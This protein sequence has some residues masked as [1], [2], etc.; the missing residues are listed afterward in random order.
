MYFTERIFITAFYGYFGK[1]VP[2]FQKMRRSPLSWFGYLIVL[3]GATACGSGKDAEPPHPAPPSSAALSYQILNILPHDARS[4]TEGLEVHDSILYESEGNYGE[5]SLSAYRLTDGKLLIQKKLDKNY[6]GE[7]I[8]VLGGRLYQL[9]YQ[10]HAVFVYHYPDLTLLR[11]GTWDHDGWGMTNDGAHLIADDGSATVYFIDPVTLKETSRLSVS[12]EHGPVNNLN[13]LE[14]VD[15]QLYANRWHSN[16]LYRIDPHTGKV[17]A[18]V[19]LGDLF[20]QAGLPFHPQD[21]SEDVLNGIA[22]RPGTKT[23]IV[24]GKHWPKSFEIKLN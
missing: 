2:L 14:Y 3:L 21:P 6:F 10:E 5:S 12:D 7:G 23:F 8:T 16:A 13:E 22:W 15:G 17:T 11:M 9:T 20:A 1:H 24:T 4:F 19:D 18:S